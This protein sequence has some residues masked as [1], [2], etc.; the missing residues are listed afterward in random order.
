M[1]WY[2][3]VVIIPFVLFLG[4]IV[5]AAFN[6]RWSTALMMLYICVLLVITIAGIGWFL[7]TIVISGPSR[8]G[9]VSC[10]IIGRGGHDRLSFTWGRATATEIVA[11]SH[12][13]ER[14]ASTLRGLAVGQGDHLWYLGLF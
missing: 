14:R 11:A 3:Y 1:A 9:R 13:P 5:T 10:W 6:K 4:V 7:F 2:S 8:A 12:L